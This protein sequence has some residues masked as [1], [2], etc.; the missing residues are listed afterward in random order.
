[1]YRVILKNVPKPGQEADYIAQWQRGSDV[2]QTY[3]G[4]LGTK[5]F[6]KVGEPGATYA[7]AD[8]VSKEAREQAFDKIKQ[9]RSDAE[10]VLGKYKEFLESWEVFAE[11]E[12]I[13][14]SPT[15]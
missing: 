3:P 8:W 2:I 7:M 1:M 4:A 11:Y 14:K 6:S 9:E 12:L 13:A 15:E 10:E 5:L